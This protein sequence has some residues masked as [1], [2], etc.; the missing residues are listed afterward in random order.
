[1]SSTPSAAGPPAPPVAFTRYQKGVVALLAT[2][3]FTIIL[4]FM[5][6]SPLGAILMPSLHITAGQFGW[7]VS[8]YAFAAGAAG[9]LA[10]GFADRFDRKKLLIVFYSGFVV[11]TLCCA[12]APNYQM[13]VFA[14]MI[15]GLF[16]GVVGSTVFAIITDLFPPQARGRVMGVVQTAFAASQVLGIP[17]GLFLANHWGWHVPF[18][19]IV[20]FGLGVIAFIAAFLQPVDAHLRLTEAR[21]GAFDHLLHTVTTPRYLQGFATTALLATGGFMLMPFGSAF[22]VNNV[23]VSMAQ[24]PLIYLFVGATSILAGP[25]VGRL[26]DRIGSLKTFAIGSSLSIVMCLIYT[27]LAITPLWIFI[28]VNVVLFVSVS[29]R[30]ISS[31][32]LISQVPAPASRGAFMAINSSVQQVSGGLAAALAGAIV[33]APAKGPLQ[34][35]EIIGYVICS[36]TAL[37][38]IMMVALARRMAREKVA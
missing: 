30:M 6:L 1:M 5:I 17:L 7:V 8:V 13:L 16:A 14:R 11:G 9:V 20:A 21:V 32:A 37:T 33:Y 31:Q 25:L 18:M 15:T 10:A 4:D 26:N 36:A 27:H 28:L 22:S 29:A 12:L 23:G 38:L 24:L 3:Q 35:F 19:A 34:H 2:L